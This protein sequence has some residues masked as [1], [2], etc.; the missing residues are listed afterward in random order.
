MATELIPLAVGAIAPDVVL[1]TA[2]TTRLAEV[3]DSLVVLTISPSQWDPTR[4]EV[5]ARLSEWYDVPDAVRL[6]RADNPEVA[7]AFGTGGNDA[8]FVIDSSRVVR[9][10]HVSGVDV[11]PFSPETPCWAGGDDVVTEDA[12]VTW[13]RRDSQAALA[14]A[15][16]I[17][18]ARVSHPVAEAAAAEPAH[19]AATTPVTLRV[20][21]RDLSLNLEPR[22]TLLDALRN[23][24]G[25]TGTKKGC[26]HGQCGSCTVHVDGKRVLSC[27]TFAIMQQGHAITTI[28]GIASSDALHPMQQAFITH[29]GFQCGYCTSGQIMSATAMVREPWGPGTMTFAKR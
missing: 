25:L 14:F 26:D 9:W 2:T 23:Y 18:F 6:I 22:V 20:N 19:T 1:T 5:I 10:R 4:D 15:A 17:A 28:E 3:C 16:A 27:L 13:S 21:G 7:H 8:A 11:L 29:D 12:I 24:A